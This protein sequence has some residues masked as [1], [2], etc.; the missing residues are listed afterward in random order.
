MWTQLEKCPL[1]HIKLESNDGLEMDLNELL[2]KG[3]KM[4]TCPN[5]LE[6][7]CVLPS[8]SRLELTMLMLC[9]FP[10]NFKILLYEGSPE[11]FFKN[12]TQPALRT[13]DDLRRSEKQLRL[14]LINKDDEIEQYKRLGGRIKYTAL[15]AYND[16]EHMKEHNAFKE[17]FGDKHISEDLLTRIVSLP[18]ENVIKNE[19]QDE[20]LKTEPNTQSTD[21]SINENEVTTVKAESI[22]A[23]TKVSRPQTKRKK[24]NI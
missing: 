11:L 6:S 21:N 18:K 24:L 4:L 9:G 8:N 1:Y 15:P 19:P 20:I 13:I 10:F 23:E 14:T 3:N 7:V 2:E 12:V 17:N 22:K 16:E 5:D